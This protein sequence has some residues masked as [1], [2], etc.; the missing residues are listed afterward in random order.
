MQEAA[1]EAAR[2]R[3]TPGYPHDLEAGIE[4]ELERY[5]PVAADRGLERLIGGVAEASFV[6]VDAP[7]ASRRKGLQYVKVL[8]KRLLSWYLRH[9]TEQV[10]VL[11]LMTARALAAVTTRLEEAEHR[12]E[13]LEKV[14]SPD[15]ADPGPVD[16]M[17]RAPDSAGSHLGQWM[18]DLEALMA[19]VG[20]RILYADADAEGVVGRL[21]AHGLDAYGVTRS[22]SPYRSSPDVRGDDVL[23]H[24]D[25]VGD[26]ALSGVVLAGCTDALDGVRFRALIE[27]LARVVRSEGRVAVMAEAPWWWTIRVGPVEADLAGARPMAAETWIAAL[28]G[29]GLDASAR[30]AGDGRSFIVTAHRR[31]RSMAP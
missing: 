22:G 13:V 12:L 25:R 27:R 11:G 1:D 15:G 26:G 21:R 29:A 31:D 10:S 14:D 8:L 7:T 18:D 23:A 5:A 3:G 28:S 9:I 2:R 16:G 20:G 19:P 6:N 4:A 24:L 30:Y 17:L